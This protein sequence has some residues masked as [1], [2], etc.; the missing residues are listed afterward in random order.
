VRERIH[1]K[2][3]RL[4]KSKIVLKGVD[5]EGGPKRKVSLKNT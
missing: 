5:V 1:Q 3:V 2:D 4:K